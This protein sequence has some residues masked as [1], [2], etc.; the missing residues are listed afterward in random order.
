ME[1]V[2]KQ[3]SPVSR[4]LEQGLDGGLHICRQVLEKLITA[5]R[6]GAEAGNRLTLLINQAVGMLMGFERR[7]GV[8]ET[9]VLQPHIY[10]NLL[11]R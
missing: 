3:K 4:L 1:N 10:A 8:G 5:A 7:A 11:L 6:G 2:K 9:P